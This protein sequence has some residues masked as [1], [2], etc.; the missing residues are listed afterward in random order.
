MDKYYTTSQQQLDANREAA[1]QKADIAY[2]KAQNYMPLVNK[3]NGLS[4]LGVSDSA[5][6]DMYNKYLNRQSGIDSSYD[7]QSADLF[8]K[9]LTDRQD[10]LNT[11]RAEEKERQYEN[12]MR[13]YNALTAGDFSDFN[14]MSSDINRAYWNG[15]IDEDAYWNLVRQAEAA[16]TSPDATY[17][18][19]KNNIYW[20]EDQ[21]M[22]NPYATAEEKATR[23]AAIEKEAKELKK[24]AYP[25][26][27]MLEDQADQWFVKNTGGTNWFGGINGDASVQLPNG[28]VLTMDEL[29]D[30][31]LTEGLT[32][33]E[34][35]D[36]LIKLQ[37]KLGI[38][39]VSPTM[40]NMPD[41][42]MR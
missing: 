10:I 37:K 13:L 39:P 41:R 7:T 18:G 28:E 15:M 31:L 29:Y 8:Q 25:Y 16:R 24:T 23:N 38:T 32:E 35:E 27:T 5:S 34:V 6:I 3:Q 19:I 26:R 11:E 21:G 22:E 30:K 9:Y 2:Q 33:D 14:T 1:T 20:Y 36:T 4:G 17:R 40:D 42:M 12:Y